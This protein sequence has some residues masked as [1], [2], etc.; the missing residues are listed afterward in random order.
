MIEPTRPTSPWPGERSRDGGI[1]E[2]TLPAGSGRLFLCGKHVVGPDPEA[3]LERAGAPGGTI[4]CLTERHELA[5]RYPA[6]LEWLD[7]H[8][9]RQPSATSPAGQSPRAFW[10]AIPDLHAPSV[11]RVGPFIAELRTRL[12]GGERVLMHCAAGIGRTGTM[13]VAVLLTYGLEASAALA[14]VGAS[15]PL[16]GPEVGAQADLIGLLAEPP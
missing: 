12:D 10:F 13:A 11:E 9:G 1:D 3:A 4:A 5:D 16:A 8:G 2:L 14:H 7:R 6:Y 15:R